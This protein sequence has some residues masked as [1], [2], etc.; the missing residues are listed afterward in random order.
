MDYVDPRAEA[1][2]LRDAF[3]ISEASK[4]PPLEP[5]L[6]RRF[7]RSAI[8]LRIMGRLPTTEGKVDGPV[9]KFFRARFV[10][11]LR[12]VEPVSTQL[13]VEFMRSGSPVYNQK[14]SYATF[15]RSSHTGLKNF[16]TG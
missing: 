10:R 4:W 14:L 9:A 12:S 7:S 5:P 16:A 13:L 15:S 8:P 11:E 1:Q 3:R 6:D 2:V